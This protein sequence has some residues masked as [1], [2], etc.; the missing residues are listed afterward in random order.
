M[1]HWNSIAAIPVTRQAH[2]NAL[3]RWVELKAKAGI[4]G[5]Q[6]VGAHRPNRRHCISS[7]FRKW[8]R[9]GRRACGEQEIRWSL[10]GPRELYQTYTVGKLNSPLLESIIGFPKDAYGQ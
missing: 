2:I 7:N 4:L 3:N 8:M 6:G 9:E 1:V 5:G 10:R